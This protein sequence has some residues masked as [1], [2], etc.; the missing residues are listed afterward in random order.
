MKSGCAKSGCSI[1]MGLIAL[2]AVSQGV[3][4]IKGCVESGKVDPETW[5]KVEQARLERQKQ[6]MEQQVAGLKIWDINLGESFSNADIIFDERVPKALISTGTFRLYLKGKEKVRQVDFTI[7]AQDDGLA[8]IMAQEKGTPGPMRMAGRKDYR[9]NIIFTDP[10]A[11]PVKAPVKAGVTINYY[12]GDISL[13]VYREPTE[14][15]KKYD[16]QIYKGR[17]YTLTVDSD[18]R[19]GL[20]NEAVNMPPIRVLDSHQRKVFVYKNEKTNS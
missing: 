9:F 6:E 5:A 14:K 12:T 13:G 17:S 10:F 20:E 1:L 18:N 16:F 19:M 4:L 7:K 8:E 11:Q 2:G 3:L 15:T